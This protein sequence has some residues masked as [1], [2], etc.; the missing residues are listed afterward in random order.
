MNSDANS[1]ALYLHLLFVPLGVAK[2]NW[3]RIV[4]AVIASVWFF[5]VNCTGTLFAGTV[6]IAKLDARDV[7]KGESVHPLF[8]FVVEPGENGE[9]FLAVHLSE[10][11]NFK[12]KMA[13]SDA[14]GT[15]S[16]L[17]SRPN[18]RINSNN[19]QI[20]YQ[21]IEE[22]PS[23]QIIEVIETYQDGDNT[24]WSRYKAT[25][26]TITPISSRMFYF[27][28]MFGAFPYAIGFAVFV[29]GMGRFFKHRNRAS[30][31]ANGDS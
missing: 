23:G 21:V 18:G 1:A 3:T 27:G 28:Y 20:S 24:I 14:T 31:V 6:L 9:P 5:P 7:D 16:F 4:I 11:P 17:M 12:G 22:T 8:S 2:V 10:L 15:N 26:S 25:Q 30:E 29:Y 19:S 13:S